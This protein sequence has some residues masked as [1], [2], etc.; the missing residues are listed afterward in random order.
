MKGDI[1]LL[2]YFLK[3]GRTIDPI[4][5]DEKI[6]HLVFVY[7]NHRPIHVAI[8]HWQEDTVN[9]LLAKGANPNR[10]EHLT[11]VD[12]CRTPLQ[13]CMQMT[14]DRFLDNCATDAT[15]SSG[16]FRILKALLE[17]GADPNVK[18]KFSDYPLRRYFSR[19]MGPIIFCI[20]Y[21]SLLLSYGANPLKLC[22]YYNTEHKC[23]FRSDLL[24]FRPPADSQCVQDAGKISK[25]Q[26][27]QFLNMRQH[28][29]NSGLSSPEEFLL[30]QKLLFTI[31][32]PLALKSQESYIS[33]HSALYQGS[34]TWHMPWLN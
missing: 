3:Y 34:W 22:K 5:T 12:Y 1:E 16:Q 7:P 25:W 21:I 31:A 4:W 17:S 18:D 27:E 20:P 23:S 10:P 15:D 14:S 2:G 19:N 13:I 30:G 32:C 6:P 28:P 9:W 33:P 26:V 11:E 24:G 8:E 29:V